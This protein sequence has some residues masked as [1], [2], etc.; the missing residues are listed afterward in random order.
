M[1]LKVENLLKVSI[2]I[3]AQLRKALALG[4][5]CLLA[6]CASVRADEASLSSGAQTLQVVTTTGI[7]ADIARH[8]GG[9]RVTVA[10]IVPDGADPHSYE[11]TPHNVR[12]IVYADIAF[13]NYLMLEEQNII[14]TL[15]SNVREGVPNISLAEKSVKYAADVIPLV[16]DVSLDTI[17]LGL[18]VEGSGDARG[19]DRSSEV[20][21]SATDVDGP[22]RLIAYLTESLGQSDVYFDSGDGF[23][24]SNGYR[25]DTVSLP[26]AAHTHLSWAFTE[27]G[28]YH[29]HVK[30]RAK[31]SQ[32]EK[33]TELGTAVVTFAVGIDPGTVA[34]SGD[35]ILREGH[36][37]ISVDLESGTFSVLADS[38]AHGEGVR[39][40]YAPESTV[41]EVPMK[42]LHEIP[43]G[44]QYRF[45]GGAGT[46]IYQLPQAV[47]GKHVPG[48]IDPHLWQNVKNVEAYAKIM[49][50]EFIALDPAGAP[51]YTVNTDLY[52]A[53]LD[54]VDSEVKSIIDSIPATE[55]HLVTTH[56]AFA[57]FGKAYG[58]DIAGF[59][60]PNPA[61]EPSLAERKRLTETIRNLH[62]KAVFL[63]P[64]LRARSSTLLEI[65]HEQNV[66]VCTIY[67]DS[68]DKN[69]RTYADMMLFNAHSIHDCLTGKKETNP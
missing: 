25:D 11:P 68:F 41:I 46:K 45:L 19:L 23:D 6:G 9:D 14:K 62:V 33:S 52:I 57:Y 17:W 13:S 24:A 18:R 22:G 51:D 66:E 59:V 36:A 31:P 69:V 10:S 42:A 26:P 27:P 65:A 63:E 38:M 2:T 47:L 49:R 8:V 39:T 3:H 67:G 53:Q 58:L 37:D 64:E 61:T 30:A 15:D 40:H 55:R 28:V 50:D 20:L 56:D 60:T 54:Q 43:S 35:T 32:E 12:D 7:L 34:Q 48:E 21:M 4:A 44:P 16:E 1:P 5:V 29:L